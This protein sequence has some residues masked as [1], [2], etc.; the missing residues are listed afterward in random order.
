MPRWTGH[1]GQDTE[2]R[3]RRTGHGGQVEKHAMSDSLSN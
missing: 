3:T 1:G 2:D